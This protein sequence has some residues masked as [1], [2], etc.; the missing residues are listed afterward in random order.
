MG[1]R[2][3]SER[4]WNPVPHFECQYC[5]REFQRLGAL[6]N[7][8]KNLHADILARKRE[9][10]EEQERER[11][12]KAYDLDHPV[13]LPFANTAPRDE[14]EETLRVTSKFAPYLAPFVEDC[15]EASSLSPPLD[16]EDAYMQNSSALKKRRILEHENGGKILHPS[17][18]AKEPP[19]MHNENVFAPF[20]GPKDFILGQYFVKNAIPQA[21]VNEYFNCGLGK[22]PVNN[23]KEEATRESI[24]FQSWHTLASKLEEIS[25][26][27]TTTDITWKKGTV[28][29]G[30]LSK[31]RG[32]P[33]DF[34]YR[35]LI[36][37]LQFLIEQP[38][39]EPSMAYKPVKVYDVN[40]DRE[41][42]EL[43]TADWW[44]RKQVGNFLHKTLPITNGSRTRSHQMVLFCL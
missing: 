26:S 27:A 34:Y 7:H 13:E 31:N 14:K 19:W 4:T 20:A 36:E 21:A 10:E 6:D 5:G 35:D 22:T 30:Q 43:N 40:G 38:Y 29:Y 41:Y 15:Q 16:D 8:V 17:D 11:L 9:K 28:S 2:K 23:K 33:V 25:K 44:W 1:R 18:P 3:N 24:T 32:R 37:S 42:G 39:L 12:L